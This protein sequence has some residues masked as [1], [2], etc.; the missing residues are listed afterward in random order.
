MS[1]GSIEERLS[2]L[3]QQ[4]QHLEKTSRGTAGVVPWWER[5][6]GAFQ[7]D[8]IYAEAMKLAREERQADRV[9]E[10]AT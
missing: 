8:T 5:V 6:T 7:G 4:V 3:E 9:E 1:S 10:S 2:R